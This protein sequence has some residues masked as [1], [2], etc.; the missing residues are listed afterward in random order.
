MYKL[1]TAPLKQ[2]TALQMSI[3][4]V[5]LGPAEAEGC[6]KA[7]SRQPLVQAEARLAVMCQMLR[8]QLVA[9]VV[10]SRQRLHAAS[11][12]TCWKIWVSQKV[13]IQQRNSANSFTIRTHEQWASLQKHDCVKLW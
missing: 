2:N 10:N 3:W 1:V 11:H 13:Y 9:K 4:I 5:I 8:L 6:W 7:V 12:I